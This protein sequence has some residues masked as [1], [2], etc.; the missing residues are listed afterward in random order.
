MSFL[1]LLAWVLIPSTPGYAQDQPSLG[2]VA[3]Q[4]RKDKEK[5]A[6]QPKR[7]ITDDNLPSSKPLGGLG[8]LGSSKNAGD[9]I[10]MARGSEALDRAET[11][12]NKLDP[13]DRATLA[14]AALL[15]NDVDF[16]N[17]PRWEDK[18][19]SAK[20]QYVSHGREL[21]QQMRQIMADVRS[22]QSSQGGQRKLSSDDPRAQELL[23][24]LQEIVQDAV[25]TENAYQSVV[26]EGWDL[27]KQAKH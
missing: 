26:M 16:P 27:A 23:R 19:Y 14:K 25:R 20:E 15:D 2:D 17:R 24:R 10:A 4:A 11:A 3:R 22:L 7:V 5:N 9:G 21:F 18:L 13:L 8:D 6:A 1:A 12:L